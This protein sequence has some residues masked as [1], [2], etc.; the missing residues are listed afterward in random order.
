MTNVEHVPGGHTSG[1]AALQTLV[2][3]SARL[4]VARDCARRLDKAHED[5]KRAIQ[6]VEHDRRQAVD[7]IEVYAE[8]V[9]GSFDPMPAGETIVSDCNDL[10]ESTSALVNE[11]ERIV[12]SVQGEKS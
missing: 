4:N 6:Q 12:R 10:V 11:A 3:L 1:A 8:A 9:P 7:A 5:I 2:E